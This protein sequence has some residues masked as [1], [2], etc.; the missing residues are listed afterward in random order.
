MNASSSHH[1]GPEVSSEPNKE[2]VLG[3]L[4]VHGGFKLDV[5]EEFA[6]G[7]LKHLSKQFLQNQN[8]KNEYQTIKERLAEGV[9][10]APIGK[11]ST[12]LGTKVLINVGHGRYLVEQNESR[13]S[14]L[15]IGDRA[16][17]MTT[18]RDN[19]NKKYNLNLKY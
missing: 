12:R 2:I 17:K 7:G 16:N 10:P 11:Q 18:F 13:V 1:P 4:A 14:I 9:D 6:T 5:V 8:V 3:A 19:I 15:A